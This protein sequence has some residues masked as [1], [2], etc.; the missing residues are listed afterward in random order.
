MIKYVKG[1][2]LG[3]TERPA[4]IMHVCNDIGA[5]GRGF[6]KS[7]SAKWDLPEKRYRAMNYHVLGS[8]DFVQVEEGL[9]VANMIAQSGI[10]SKVN[11]HPLKYASLALCTRK[12]AIFANENNATVHAPK[13]GAGLAGG[14]WD[15]IKVIL[16]QGIATECDVTIYEL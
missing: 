13:L 4:V 11:P 6:V 7:V 15:V 2:V 9:W 8:V 5:W 14:S 10:R 16:E 12:V 3:V 1:D